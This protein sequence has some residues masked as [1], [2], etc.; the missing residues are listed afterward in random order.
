MILSLYF[1]TGTPGSL[2]VFGNA[3]HSYGFH[4]R[5]FGDDLTSGHAPV[6][7]A[8]ALRS[9]PAS[10][11]FQLESRSALFPAHEVSGTPIAVLGVFSAAF[12]PSYS[13]AI[14]AGT[15]QSEV[16][17]IHTARASPCRRAVA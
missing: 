15:R 13:S 12:I 9:R 14:A 3:H 10:C 5:N 1:I 4:D 11:F 7:V 2:A 16:D 8:E 17:R 6:Y